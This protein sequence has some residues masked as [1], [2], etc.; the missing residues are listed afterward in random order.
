MPGLLDLALGRRP[1]RSRLIRRLGRQLLIRRHLVPG[2]ERR[3]MGSGPCLAPLLSG[4]F[5]AND[6]VR[7]VRLLGDEERIDPARF[8]DQGDVRRGL[9]VERL[10]KGD[11]GR[12]GQVPVFGVSDDE[13]QNGLARR[14]HQDGRVTDL[15]LHPDNGVLV[16][17]DPQHG[18][19]S[20][21]ESD[22]DAEKGQRGEPNGEGESAHRF[23]VQGCSDHTVSPG[24]NSG[25]GRM[26]P[27]AR[28]REG[29]D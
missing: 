24:E 9:L 8:A 1:R 10:E 19:L 2:N 16:L 23:G 12:S 11:V 14:Q 21:G 17:R 29:I 4:P 28:R 13:I 26:S 15:G 7:G 6:Q 3:L 25:A 5:D 20:P 22:A 18:A 27:G